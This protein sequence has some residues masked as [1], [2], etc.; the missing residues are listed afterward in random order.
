MGVLGTGVV[1]LGLPLSSPLLDH[2]PQYGRIWIGAGTFLQ[3]LALIS[4]SYATSTPILILTQGLLYS[5]GE[6]ILYMPLLSLIN[7]WFVQKRGL[8]YG[9]LDGSTG[10]T[11][12]ALPFVL[13]ALL[14]RYGAAVTLR[15]YAVTLAVMGPLVLYFLRARRTQS[16]TQVQG[17]HSNH[18]Q[19]LTVSSTN[20]ISASSTL[21]TTSPVRTLLRRH[22]RLFKRPMFHLYSINIVVQGFGFYMPQIFL[23]TYVNTAFHFSPTLGATLIALVSFSQVIGQVVF[24]ALS[25]RKGMSTSWLMCISS[26]CSALATL[27]LWGLGESVAP[28]LIYA[29]AYGFLAS[30]YQ[31]LWARVAMQLTPED[32][33]PVALVAYALFCAQRGLG[34]VLSGPLSEALIQDEGPEK[35]Q[36][37]V[38]RLAFGAHRYAGIVGFTG[39]CL[40]TSAILS[41]ITAV[42]VR[43]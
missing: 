8:A 24:G 15:A 10:V 34:N 26:G 11:G 31:I 14:D 42:F 25:D 23:P 9:L 43:R 19:A 16:P 40:A 4:A 29:I 20:T 39:G 3:I 37:I 22:I 2:Y 30:G 21:L 1:H 6:L 17:L 27:L 35:D 7:D 33:A 13:Q 41:A 18:S 38:K 32:D 28:L 5:L 12:T 36:M